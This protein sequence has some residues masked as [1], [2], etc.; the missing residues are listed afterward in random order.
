MIRYV[1]F[2][3]ILSV[4]LT[5]GQTTETEL[6]LRGKFRLQ[7]EA[8]EGAVRDFSYVLQLNEGHKDALLYRGVAHLKMERADLAYTDLSRQIELHGGNGKVYFHRSKAAQA[9]GEKEMA[10]D[11]IRIALIYEPKEPAFH[12]WYARLLL[13]QKRYEE[14]LEPINKAI[15]FAPERFDYVF[16]RI[17]VWLG[18][19]EP[20]IALRDVAY[21]V[22]IIPKD[23]RVYTI[24]AAIYFQ[25]GDR[26]AACKD[27]GAA[28]ALGDQSVLTLIQQF[29]DQRMEYSR[30]N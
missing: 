6:Y 27:W 30:N 25:E 20:E 8:F 28:A 17:E 23:P 13:S 2:T 16:D 24:R 11:D 19:E 18:L 1:W 12:H 29:C 21:L 3:L 7:D 14:A 4:Q 15:R 9:Q 10:L 22:R 26:R 5:W